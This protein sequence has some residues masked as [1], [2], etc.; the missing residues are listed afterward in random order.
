[1]IVPEGMQMTPSDKL[2]VGGGLRVSAGSAAPLRLDHNYFEREVHPML[3]SILVQKGWVSH[4]RLDEALAE[5]KVT[6]MRLGETLLARGWLLGPE[7]SLPPSRSR[8]ASGTSIWY[9]TRSI[10]G[11]QLSCRSKLLVACSSFPCASSTR[12][13][14]RSRS[15]TLRTSTSRSRVEEAHGNDEHAT[16][17]FERHESCRP[18]IERVAYQ[19]D[20]PEAGLLRE[21]GGEF[22]L[23]EPAT[24]KKCLAEAHAGDLDLRERL[25]QALV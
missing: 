8:P 20:V 25:V 5:V 17:N 9:V 13:A 23:E 24:G 6:G 10:R 12:D 4:E 19:I 7:L 1:M 16:S 21:G 2:Y 18:R 22:G 15:A 11:R 14:S 3:G